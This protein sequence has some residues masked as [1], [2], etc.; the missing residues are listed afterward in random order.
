MSMETKT[1]GQI[2]VLP[3][4]YSELQRAWAFW[5]LSTASYNGV[6]AGGFVYLLE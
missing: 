1:N 5:M 2:T 6:L 4:F 3:Q